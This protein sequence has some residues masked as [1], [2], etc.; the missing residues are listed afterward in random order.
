[1]AQEA[2]LKLWRNPSQLR[3]AHL[4]AF[5]GGELL[6]LGAASRVLAANEAP[7]DP[8]TATQEMV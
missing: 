7:L 1:M 3:E 4:H 5:K 8:S 2:F 6:G